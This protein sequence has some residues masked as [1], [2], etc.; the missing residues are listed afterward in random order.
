[1]KLDTFQG[2][3]LAFI[4]LPIS[5][6]ITANPN[7]EAS[8]GSGS[9]RHLKIADVYL[10]G[11]EEKQ[12]T[13]HTLNKDTYETDRRTPRIN[14]T[15]VLKI[16]N[17]TEQLNNPSCSKPPCTFNSIGL[18]LNGKKVAYK[19]PSEGL[20]GNK[21]DTVEFNLTYGANFSDTDRK[22]WVD[23]MGAPSFGID[24]WTDPVEVGIRVDDGQ[25]IKYEEGSIFLKT[26]AITDVYLLGMDSPKQTDLKKSQKEYLEERRTVGI[27]DT[28][29]LKINN[30]T[31]LVKNLSCSKPPCTPKSISLYLNGKKIADRNPSAG[32]LGKDM[33]TVEFDLNY[34]MNGSGINESDGEV[35]KKMNE[36]IK[37]NWADLLGSPRVGVF[38]ER[39]VEV[40]VSVNDGAYIKYKGPLSLRRIDFE[41]FWIFVGVL[42][43]LVILLGARENSRETI[44]NALSDIGNMPDTG[45]FKP[46]SLA[47]CQ[48]AFW[49]VLVALSFLS[50][51]VVTGALDT[52]T[53]SV[54]TLIGIASGSALGSAFIDV[55]VDDQAKLDKLQERKDKLKVVI[56][57]LETDVTDA[58]KDVNDAKKAVDDAKKD[59]NDAKKAVNDA[60]IAVNNNS[61]T[62]A[63]LTLADQ[64]L[65]NAK[66]KSAEKKLKLTVAQKNE[67]SAKKLLE[68]I[69][70]KI[71]NRTNGFWNDI[72]NDN[73][74]AGFHRI[75]MFVWTLILGGIFV[76]SVWKSLSMPVFDETL[77]A[78]Q[79]ISAGTYLGFKLPAKQV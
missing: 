11:M 66:L 47:R 4:L 26:P 3:L 23:L 77:L 63:Q 56:P 15:L 2:Y 27:N 71:S 12:P 49:F 41:K 20:L 72:F 37:K 22:N 6:S 5:F 1:M 14:D 76:Y 42:F 52:I 39:P 43:F 70:N 54:L 25:Y 45:G 64:A 53:G 8:A 65:K 50:I 51:W 48:M 61:S 29:V 10:L 19:K 18:Y 13:D 59:V 34:G 73:E 67:K 28:L 24:H 36:A 9:D 33:D 7:S 30:L 74:S 17:L 16:N 55:S 57:G 21:S 79:G 68:Y 78:L 44:R 60:Q 32:P 58:K 38:W 35:I 75:Q 46:W 62:P 40:A 69:E 31:E